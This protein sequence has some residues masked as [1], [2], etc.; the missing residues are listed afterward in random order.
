VCKI[1]QMATK[2][3]NI[4]QSKAL[5][6]CPK[7]GFSGLKI[8]HLAT[9]IGSVFIICSFPFYFRRLC[10]TKEKLE[11]MIRRCFDFVDRQQ[12]DQIG[13]IFAY[14][15][16]VYF[17]QFFEN[18]RSSS[19]F[20]C[21]FPRLSLCIDFDMKSVGIHFGDF[22]TNLSGHPGRQTRPEV[23]CTYCVSPLWIRVYF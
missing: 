2:Y 1:F 17:G 22:F 16:N 15:A 19:I 11:W 9:L 5:Q 23:I 21:F 14:R 18:H 8:N 4:F 10:A 7:F 12:G 20:G 3:I 6:N 13:R